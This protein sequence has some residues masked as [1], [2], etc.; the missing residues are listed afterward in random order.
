VA[1]S[2]VASAEKGKQEQAESDE[3]QYMN[4]IAVAVDYQDTDD[5]R[6]EKS[7]CGLEEH[8]ASDAATRSGNEQDG[9]A[10]EV[11]GE[12]WRKIEITRRGP[13]EETASGGAPDIFI[14]SSHGR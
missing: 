7:E 4:E 14:R 2:R 13:P 6:D 5:P 1:H 8:V 11:V 12:A 3:Q 10:L 9:D